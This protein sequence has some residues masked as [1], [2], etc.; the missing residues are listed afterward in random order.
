MMRTL[1]EMLVVCPGDS[2]ETRAALRAALAQ[3]QPIYLRLGKKGEPKVHTS[4]P[5]L[6]L[7][8]GLT[9]RQGAQVVLLSTGNVLPVAVE[10]AERLRIQGID[11]G[12]ISLHTVKPLDTALLCECFASASLVA[13]LEEHSIIGGLGGAVAEWLADQVGTHA[14][15]IR[16]GT[17]DRFL[18]S[19]GGQAYARREFGLDAGAITNALSEAVRREEK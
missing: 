11:A 18:R 10:V 14:R 13:T 19:A 8:R 15:L 6:Q 4:L 5:D 3:S 1:P 16:I 12:V 17:P 2:W 9:V 7:G